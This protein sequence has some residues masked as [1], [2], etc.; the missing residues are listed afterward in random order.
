MRILIEGGR[1]YSMAQS[2]PLENGTIMI[3]DEKIESVETAD[4]VDPS[5]VPDIK[6]RIPGKTVLPGLIDA[7]LH[8]GSSGHPDYMGQR[9]KETAPFAAIRASVH[10]RKVLDAGFT[11]IRDA[12]TI[13]YIDVACKKAINDG[14]TPGPRMLVSG[15]MLLMTGPDG[16]FRPEVSFKRPGVVNSPDEARY[17]ARQELKM[18]ADVLKLIASGSIVADEASP[19]GAPQLTVEEMR[20][21]IEEA[22]KMGKRAMAHAHGAEAIKNAILA[23]IDSIEHGTLIDQECIDLM[24]ERGVFLV[25][26]LAPTVR[27]RQY[28]VKSGIPKY[29]I[30]RMEMI[31]EE[32]APKLLNAVK[33]GVKIALGTDCGMPFFYHGENAYELEIL[34]QAGLSPRQALLSATKGGAECLGL[35]SELG[36]LESGKLASLLIVEGDPFEDIRLLQDLSKIKF[37]MKEGVIYKNTLLKEELIE[38]GRD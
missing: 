26:T 20:A 15:H 16:Y 10:A 13:G 9:I 1:V 5:K 6:F 29:M 33:Q 22:H 4:R 7:H 14:L 23:G 8:V 21:A 27:L 37:I 12:G 35:E 28:G 18:G 25:P 11:A 30:D 32:R 31:V 17:A 3:H 24:L 2:S 19:P 34:V 36:T 38:E